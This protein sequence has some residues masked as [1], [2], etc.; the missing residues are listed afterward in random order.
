MDALQRAKRLMAE[1][2]PRQHSPRAE[3]ATALT[4]ISIA[5]TLEEILPIL[6]KIQNQALPE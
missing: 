3:H 1:D 2:A 6:R 5:E 4:L